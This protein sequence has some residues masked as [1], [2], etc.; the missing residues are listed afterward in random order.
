VVRKRCSAKVREIA[1]L[2]GLDQ[3]PIDRLEIEDVARLLANPMMAA[4]A[5]GA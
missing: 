3:D 5:S 1:R 4:S 2:Q